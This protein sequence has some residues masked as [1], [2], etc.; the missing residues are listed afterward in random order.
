MSSLFSRLF[1]H[2]PRTADIARER[3]QLVIAHER[4][5]QNNTPDFLPAL[6][7]DLV[8]V[9]SRYVAVNPEDIKVSLEREDNC[10]IL[11]VNIMLPEIRPAAFVSA[12]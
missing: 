4:N 8:A 11:E 12:P 6:Q 2:K 10:E 9:I 1:R 7:K 5:A 3:L